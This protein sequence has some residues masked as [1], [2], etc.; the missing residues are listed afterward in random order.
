MYDDY[1][2]DDDDDDDD[3]DEHDIH[4]DDVDD[5]D[6]YADDVDDDN[7]LSSN[8]TG[9]SGQEGWWTI[10]SGENQRSSSLFN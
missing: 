8:L 4:V 3:V 7:H 10:G 9:G 1:D 5:V 2:D 6:D